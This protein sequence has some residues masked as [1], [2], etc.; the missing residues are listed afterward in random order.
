VKFRVYGTIAFGKPYVLPFPLP[1]F[2]VIFFPAF[3][4][5][6][7]PPLEEVTRTSMTHIGFLR[8]FPSKLNFFP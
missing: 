4:R 1:T 3:S 2:S 5:V 7:A 8:Y 6:P